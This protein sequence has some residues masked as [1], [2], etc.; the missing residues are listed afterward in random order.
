MGEE[1]TTKDELTGHELRLSLKIMIVTAE[2]SQR[3]ELGIGDGEL[4]VGMVG[5]V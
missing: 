1:I 5:W 3:E 4:G 2:I